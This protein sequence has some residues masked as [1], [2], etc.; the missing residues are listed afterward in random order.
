MGLFQS[1]EN[2]FSA[3]VSTG[4]NSENKL[5]KPIAHRDQDNFIQ[6]LKNEINKPDCNKQELEQMLLEPKTDEFLLSEECEKF[7]TNMIIDKLENNIELSGFIKRR[8]NINENDIKIDKI[9][10]KLESGICNYLLSSKDPYTNHKF[11]EIIKI[12][13]IEKDKII[14][15]T[16]IQN[17][18][19]NYC[20]R[21]LDFNLLKEVL[22]I[23]DFGIVNN[24]FISSDIFQKV[25]EKSIK[26]E[27]RREIQQGEERIPGIHKEIEKAKKLLIP[28][29]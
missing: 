2:F 20:I 17:E 11:L 8:F 13:D 29:Q 15:S 5:T 24:D 6:K 12:F 21:A 16:K 7:A 28:R 3:K 26:Y 27:K 23:I 22:D 25:L 4:N 10:E 1:M 19:N 9:W 18:L 14:N